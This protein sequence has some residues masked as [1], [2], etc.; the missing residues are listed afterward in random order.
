MPPPLAAPIPS[1]STA[2]NGQHHR[3]ITAANGITQADG[4]NSIHLGPK[5][6]DDD[7][8]GTY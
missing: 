3:E 1:A 8:E 2:G 7:G 4:A 6:L 5:R